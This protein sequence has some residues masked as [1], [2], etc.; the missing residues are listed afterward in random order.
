MGLAPPTVNPSSM[1]RFRTLALLLG[2]TIVLYFSYIGA[3]VFLRNAE[4]IPFLD[5]Y[6]YLFTDSAIVQISI[7][8]VTLILSFYWFGLY[9]ELRVRSRRVLFENLLLIWG[10]VFLLQAIS[11][12][13][14]S[15]MVLARWV[16]LFGS[17][18][19][20]ILFTLWRALYSILLLR[21]VDR[22]RVLFWNDSA[23]TREIAS[24]IDAHAEK[25]YLCIG[26]ITEKPAFE[27]PFLG[28]PLHLI[29]QNTSSLIRQLKPSYIAICGELPDDNHIVATLIDLN[30]HHVRI[31][32]IAEIYEDL[33]Q[34]IPLQ[35][36]TTNNL[37]F[38]S[39]LQPNPL[40]VTMQNVYGT[41]VAILGLLL[42]WPL[43]ILT[44]IAV[45]LDSP[46]PAL[47][48]QRRIG[49]NG[50]IFEIL[51]FRSMYVDA[52][53]RFGR[54][55]ASDNDPRIT[56][57]GRFIRVSRLDELP[58]FINVLVGDMN[59]VG[60]RPEMPEYV[61]ELTRALPL[62]TQR[63]RVKPGITGWAQLHHIPELSI[64]ETSRKIQHDLYYIKHLSPAFDFLIM[65]HTL[66]AILLRIGAR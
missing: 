66:K 5:L 39:S 56:R 37:V 22:Q 33:F 31:A 48:R 3:Y 7:V 2:D 49:K 32:N 1:P 46:G 36:L 27:E 54:T 55:R 13:A 21:V 28:G 58:Q 61:E 52:D 14:K 38:A 60:P 6:D 30:M 65:F 35:T 26:C 11:S 62:Y 59:L 44:A 51:K 34:Q 17:T 23:I 24:H 40:F 64:V 9:E 63:L 19:A 16:M 29:D 45:K 43:M 41:L 4:W 18:L 15:P 12:Y 42:T 47:L 53:K 25:G 50:H 10:I 8:S 20:I 57:I